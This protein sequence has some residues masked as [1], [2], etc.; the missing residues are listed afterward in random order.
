MTS[1]TE[2]ETVLI[3]ADELTECCN[4]IGTLSLGL[5]AK[6]REAERVERFG[7]GEQFGIVV[8]SNGGNLNCSTCWDEL[9]IGQPDVFQYLSLEGSYTC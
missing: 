1:K 6:S 4:L 7:I 5:V 3:H 8:D 2:G 9:A